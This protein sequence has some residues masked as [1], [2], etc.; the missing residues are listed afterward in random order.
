MGTPPGRL[1]LIS[2]QALGAHVPRR[3]VALLDT[4]ARADHISREHVVRRALV[5]EVEQHKR[6]SR[7]DRQRRP[8]T[9]A[10]FDAELE[11]QLAA[12]VA[13][14]KPGRRQLVGG[15]TLGAHAHETILIPLKAP[16][17]SAHDAIA[18]RRLVALLDTIACA[19]HISRGQVV[20]RALV[21]EVEQHIRRALRTLASPT[22]P[23]EQE[24]IDDEPD[25]SPFAEPYAR[26]QARP[27]QPNRRRSMGFARCWV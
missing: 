20:K 10:T 26:S 15:Q 5:R 18:R 22:T 23:A 11:A 6:L 8:T 1:Q 3:L 12:I 4:I 7:R 14:V 2:S 16:N 19:D 13:N 27:P 9:C 24:A 25:R 21:R 17:E